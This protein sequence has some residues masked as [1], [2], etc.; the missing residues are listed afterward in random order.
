MLGAGALVVPPL[1]RRYVVAV[2]AGGPGS[3]ML[4][5]S[6]LDAWSVAAHPRVLEGE[7]PLRVA[8]GLMAGDVDR[9][10][11]RDEFVSVGGGD[12]EK[13]IAVKCGCQAA[14]EVVGFGQVGWEVVPQF[15]GGEA[16]VGGI[17]RGAGVPEV[18]V[19][20]FAA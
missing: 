1:Q 2:G 3:W 13:A 15:G 18:D 6:D 11:D 20:H 7:R 8:V 17:E 10:C 19:P 4:D 16:E 14:D 9:E 12:R 5:A